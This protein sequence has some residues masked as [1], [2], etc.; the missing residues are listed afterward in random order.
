MPK[1]TLHIVVAAVLALLTGSA[2][3]AEFNMA[4]PHVE[5][6]TH[7]A[8][9]AF[10][11]TP[12]S[13]HRTARD[14]ILPG[15]TVQPVVLAASTESASSPAKGAFA[16]DKP[17]SSGPI[18]LKANGLTAQILTQ[19]DRWNNSFELQVR[20]LIRVLVG[21]PGILEA[22]GGKM[23]GAADQALL[24]RGALIVAA[25]FALG[26]GMEWL[27][28]RLLVSL[29]TSFVEHAQQLD[30]H[31]QPASMPEPDARAETRQPAELSGMVSSEANAKQTE[32][33][34][35]MQP[36]VAGTALVQ[37]QRDGIDLVES[38][39]LDT[40]TPFVTRA[41]ARQGPNA[42][43]GD[44][45]AAGGS[46]DGTPIVTRP[47]AD[48]RGPSGYFF[49]NKLWSSLRQLPFAMGVLLL[50]LLP[51]TVFF[52]VTAVL[53]HWLGRNDMTL[54][55]VVHILVG[56]YVGMQAAIAVLRLVVA[57]AGCGVPVLSVRADIAD[58]LYHGLRRMIAAAAF[59]VALAGLVQGL[60]GADEGRLV[61]L[62]LV[63][64]VVHLLAVILIY[65][66]RLPVAARI[67]G[68][69]YPN[70]PLGTARKWLAETWATFSAILVIG[71]W[72]VW[73]FGLEDGF[74]R[75]LQFVGVTAAIIITARILA[76]LILGLLGRMFDHS[77]VTDTLSSS[78]SARPDQ[79]FPL[80][81]RLIVILI[82]ICTVLALLQAWGIDVTGWLIERPIGRRLSSAVVTIAV[83]VIFGIAVWEVANSTV[84]RHL[85]AWQE[86]GDTVRAAR[87]R[88]LLPILKTCLFIIIILVVC[89]TTLNEIGINTAPLLA[90]A[91]IVGVAVG[92]GSQKLVQD[93]ITGIFLLMENAMQ[94]GEWV[95]V[96]GV[97]GVVEDLSIRTVRLRAGDGSLHI[98]P[99]S[100]VSTVNNTNRGLGNA[101]M[102]V[103]VVYGTDIEAVTNELK[104]IGKSLREDPG[105]AA[106]IISDLEVWGVDAV[107]GSSV[108][109]AGQIRC[110]DKGRWGVQRELNRRILERFRQR[111]ILIADP[112]ATVF[113]PRDA[114]PPAVSAV[115][116][117]AP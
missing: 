18:P 9:P 23:A 11:G 109:L 65:R 22:V 53:L 103:S 21:L 86:Q 112:R 90:S 1:S 85:N 42:A 6:A 19:V 75:L 29:R 12:H 78:G 26:V 113:L 104:E 60:G 102:R 98:V 105:F 38:I 43:S 31:I 45:D 106:N 91:S 69:T 47:T 49:A 83:A 24:V 82:S 44:M 61:T 30:R 68:T 67:A 51:L 66:L 63:S 88:T 114:A 5:S 33:A 57:P 25:I 46:G 87:L 40:N 101:V 77:D 99:F 36:P 73:A 8:W 95:T 2:C 79:Y 115:Q 117:V 56:A 14:L 35:G 110:T 97:S 96:A 58:I 48:E 20:Q 92:F 89:L 37:S 70:S 41:D 71:I 10:T 7:A 94:V 15:A 52:F 50:D 84:D 4:S 54:R 108:T 39:P 13:L 16:S 93:F 28:R 62:K 111:N 17:A 74:P 72:V 3:A 59:G 64:L 32:K 34:A 76:I 116:H 80:V 100:S 81:Q 55:E 27:L 107:D